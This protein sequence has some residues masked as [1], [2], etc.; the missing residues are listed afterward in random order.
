MLT[1]LFVAALEADGERRVADEWREAA[2]AQLAD[3][4]FGEYYEPRTGEAL[5]GHQQSWTAAVAVD[6]SRT[7]A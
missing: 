6:R 4:W 3:L 1:W 2:L 5:G 7:G